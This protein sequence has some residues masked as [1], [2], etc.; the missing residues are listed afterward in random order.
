MSC[1]IGVSKPV[2]D[3]STAGLVTAHTSSLWL[4]SGNMA[5]AIPLFEPPGGDFSPRPLGI[6]GKNW[7]M[8][9]VGSSN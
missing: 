9:I 6:E 3:G 7:D 1:L 4:L 8:C 2:P 5:M